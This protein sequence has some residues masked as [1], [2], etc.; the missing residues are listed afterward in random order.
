MSAS[1][2]LFG[3]LLLKLGIVTPSQ[4]QEAL[5]LQALTGQRVGEALI[6]LGYVT[7]EQIQDALG[8]ALGLTSEKVGPR[9]RRWASC[10]WGSSTSPWRSSTRRSAF[11]RK[12]GRKLGEILVEKG[13]CTYK[14]IYE[15]LEPAGAHLRPPGASAAP[16]TEGKHRV[17]VVDDSPLA[18]AFVQEGLEALGYEVLLLRGSVQGAGAGGPGAAGHR[19]DA[20]WTCRA[21]TAWSCAGG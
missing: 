14:Q 20:T 12:D 3:D 21:S 18:C 13:Y 19:A 4:V 8:E 17:M 9:S 1:S 6:S 10:W 11:Q 7:R 15:A 2:P 16:A 5:A